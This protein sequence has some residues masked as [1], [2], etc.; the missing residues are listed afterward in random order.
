MFSCGVTHG[1]HLHVPGFGAQGATAA[2]TKGAFDAHGNG[3]VIN[4]SRSLTFP[5][6]ASRAGPSEWKQEIAAACRAMR[7][8]LERVRRPAK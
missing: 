8:D 6:G 5:W 1:H 4:A 2:D 7:D 3:A